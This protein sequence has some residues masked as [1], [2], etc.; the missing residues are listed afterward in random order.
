[1]KKVKWGMIGTGSVTEVKSGPGFYKSKNSE[2]YG[3]FNR[4]RDKAIDWAKRHGINKVYETIDEMLM[5]ENIDAIYIAT[6]PNVH[7]EYAIRCLEAGKIP[8]I[9]KP[10]AF[11]Y[12]ECQDILKVSNEKNIPVYVAFYRRGMEKY[13]KIKELLDEGVLGNIKYVEVRQI[14]KPEDSDL[15]REKLPWRVIPEITGGGKFIDMGVHVLDILDFFFGHI[16]VAKGMATNLGG[17]YDVEDTVSA[18][19]MFEN[20]VVGNGMWCYVAGHEEEYVR[21]VGDKGYII[22]EG[23]GYGP[24]KIYDG[25]EVQELKF[26]SP[27]HV[28]QPYIQQVVDEIIGFKKSNANIQ[29]AA[30]VTRIT[31]EILRNFTNK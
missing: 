19:F 12:H 24:V 23:L 30:N 9:E 13:I 1:M 3:V 29:S 18:S 6:P 25:N 27:D 15:N 31:D 10:M 21:I 7:K 22:F 28:A 14:M 26:N 4:N 8:Y 17:Y 16:N 5:D 2:L 11:N 20:G